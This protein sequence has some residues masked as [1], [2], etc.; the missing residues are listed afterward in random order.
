MKAAIDIGT[1]SVLMLVGEPCGGGEVRPERDL[2]RVTRLGEGLSTSGAISPEAARRTLDVLREYRSVCLAAGV[3]EIAAVGTAAMRTAS[4]GE[5]FLK[6][7]CDAV[8][9]EIEVLS[10]ERESSLAF[11]PAAKSFG[12]D[13]VVCDIGGGSTEFTAFDR[14]GTLRCT[15]LPVGCVS[16][17]ERFLAGDPETNEEVYRLRMEARKELE[18][19]LDPELYA[20]PHDKTFVAAA[21]TAS[22]L[23]S[24]KLRLPSYDPEL[25]HGAELS[26]E[27]LRDLIDLMRPKRIDERRSLPG[28]VPERADV[29]L[30]GAELLQEIM[31]YLGYS[32]ARVSDRGV[33]WGLFYEKFCS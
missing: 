19:N 29:I 4:N 31:S 30:A 21:G 24:M 12:N 5:Q 9:A 15:S 14:D 27:E 16:L 17:T 6:E 32:G 23:A 3:A 13:I 22:T 28:L 2:M 8:G 1:N 10:E 18:D 7:A 26:L 33:R 20:R 11:A 25:I